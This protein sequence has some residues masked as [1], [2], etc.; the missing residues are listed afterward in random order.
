[1]GGH[2]TCCVATCLLVVTTSQLMKLRE[3]P[4]SGR[5]KYVT[6]LT[7]TF[8]SALDINL[9]GSQQSHK[10]GRL[11]LRELGSLLHCQMQLRTSP[12]LVLDRPWRSALIYCSSGRSR[13]WP[14]TC[15]VDG[16]VHHRRSTSSLLQQWS[17][18][19]PCHPSLTARLAVMC[20]LELLQRLLKTSGEWLYA[21]LCFCA[22]SS[23]L[24][25]L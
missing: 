23:A 18:S 21:S 16:P 17:C 22:A 5:A 12:G 3:L 13:S 24:T 14:G 2:P 1:M 19:R 4:G 11:S 20:E 15:D 9:Q 8:S 25:F 6:P 10:T 7:E